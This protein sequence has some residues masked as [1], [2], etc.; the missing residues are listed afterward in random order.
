MYKNFLLQFE[1][2]NLCN[3]ECEICM[4][5]NLDRQEGFASFDLFRHL[6]SSGR[7]TYVGF[8]GWGEP[9]LNDEIFDMIRY[10]D[11][12]GMRTG[13]ITNGT[14]I[15]DKMDDIFSSNLYE[16]A[17]GVH[18]LDG[19]EGIK[20]DIRLL[21]EERRKKGSP[22][23]IFLDIT[24]YNRNKDEVFK[25]I[26]GAKEIGVRY[27]NLHQLFDLYGVDPGV[28]SLSQ[29]DYIELFKYARSLGRMLGMKVFFSKK[30]KIPCRIVRYSL[31]VTWDGYLTPCCFLPNYHF[32]N[33]LDTDLKDILISERYKDFVKNM[34]N[35]EIC[36][37]CIM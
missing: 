13:L 24:A 27:I 32:G 5:K 26:E 21:L 8:H 31:F 2:T 34:A 22:L 16:I 20:K 29:S 25:I 28:K 35:N 37:R 4:R 6:I 30:H 9:F 17:F 11:S 10:A 1:P 14:L 15:S 36:K 18:R 12:R 33:V 19:L 3:H 23:R 7:F